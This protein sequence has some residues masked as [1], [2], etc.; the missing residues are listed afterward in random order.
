MLINSGMFE[1]TVSSKGAFR[2]ASLWLESLYDTRETIVI[3]NSDGGSGYDKDK[4]D[5][6][7]GKCQRMNILEILFMLIKNK[8]TGVF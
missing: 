1:S 8:T 2:R 4:F 7:I 6:M 3:S 5:Q